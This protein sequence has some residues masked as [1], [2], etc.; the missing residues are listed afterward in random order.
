MEKLEKL[1][2]WLA[3]GNCIPYMEF[4]RIYDI[5][6]LTQEDKDIFVKWLDINNIGLSPQ[7]RLDAYMSINKDTNEFLTTKELQAT[8]L[9]EGINFVLSNQRKRKNVQTSIQLLA[10]SLIKIGRVDG[11]VLEANLLK[12]IGASMK[13]QLMRLYVL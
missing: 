8:K 3:T 13:V 4:Y 10:I 11:L 2:K 6:S 9:P 1:L 12:L 7:E 5:D